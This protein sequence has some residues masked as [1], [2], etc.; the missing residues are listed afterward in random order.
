MKAV[1]KTAEKA[2]DTDIELQKKIFYYVYDAPVIGNYS[3]KN[4]FLLRFE[5]IKKTFEGYKNIKVLETIEVN[6]E[7]EI[8]NLH[9]QWF[10][11]GYEGLMV[12]NKDMPYE[13]KRTHNLLKMKN[14]QDDEFE[15]L[16]INEGMGGLAGKA[17]SFTVKMLDG[18]EFDAKLI[19]SF[20]RLK[21]V[22]ENQVDVI[23]KM[24]TVKYQNLTKYG[25]PR[26]PVVK[27][28]RGLV[29]RTDW[30]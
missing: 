4:E 3:Q 2:N 1:R 26:F 12:R 27:S 20:E 5:E 17:G 21:W 30:V 19:G 22:F 14:F 13:G 15:I 28:V 10:E 8:I 23:G 29:D 24:A 25:I 16:K 11:D 9:N 6:N 18:K 7:E